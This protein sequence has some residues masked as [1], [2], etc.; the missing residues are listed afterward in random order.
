MVLWWKYGFFT[1]DLWCWS[2][3]VGAV[4]KKIAVFYKKTYKI[5]C[6]FGKMPY[7]CTRF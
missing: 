1:G 6:K 7:L 4:Y 3:S 2:V 5:F